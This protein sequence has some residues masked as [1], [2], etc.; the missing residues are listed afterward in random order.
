MRFA[1]IL[2]PLPR[3]QV[4]SKTVLNIRA[5]NFMNKALQSFNTW[6]TPEFTSINRLPM[7]STLYPYPDEASA[8]N[9]PPGRSRL[10]RS[11]NG[12]W[13]FKFFAKP[14]AVPGKVFH[15]SDGKDNDW[16][17]IEV[18]GNWTVQGYDRPHY[19]N[20]I[21]PFE[22]NPPF[23]PADNPTGVY[24]RIFAVPKKWLKRRTILHIGGMESCGYVYLN[25]QFIGMTKDSRLPAEFD[26]SP[27]LKEGDNL[28]SIMV[29]RWS[30]GSYVEDQDHWWMAG[31]H[32]DV[33]LYNTDSAYIEDVH[34]EPGLVDNYT[35]GELGVTVKLNFRQEPD[36]EYVVECQLFDSDHKPVF[37]TSLRKVINPS[38]RQDY[39]QASMTA[40]AGSVRP[41]SAEEPSLYTLVVS[42]SDHRGKLIEATRT[43]IGFRTV[44]IKDRQLL[45]NGAP[46][47]IKGVNRHDHD[48]DHGK[49][50]S[51]EMMLKDILLLK[52]FN[53][54]AVRTSHYPNDPMWYQLCDE[55]GIYVIDEANI[56]S[57][58]NPSMLCRDLRWQR[59]WFE[60]GSRMVIRDKNH[61]SIIGWSLGNESGYGENHDLLAHWIRDYDPSRILHYEGAVRSDWRQHVTDFGPGGERAN[62][63]VDPMYPHY[64]DVVEWAENPTDRKRPFIMCEYSH[65]MGNSNGN[66]KEYWDAVYKYHGLQGG[67]IWDWVDQGLRKKVP[68]GGRTPQS[69]PGLKPDEFWAYGGDFGDEPNDINFCC[70]GMIWPDRTPHPA[71]YEFKKLVQPIKVESWDIEKGVIEIHNTDFFINANWLEGEWRV[72]VDGRTVQRGELPLLDIGPQTK[73]EISVDYRQPDLKDGE[74]AFLTI[75]FVTGK[76][77]AWA[78]KGHL[79]AWEQFPLSSRRDSRIA[80]ARGAKGQLSLRE[81]DKQIVVADQ[82]GGFELTFDKTGGAVSGLK[83]DGAP[84]ITQ[85]P[86]FNIWR[87]PLDNDGIKGREKEWHDTLKPLGW[88]IAMGYDK[89]VRRKTEVQTVIRKNGRID[90]KVKQ[91]FSSRNGKTGFNH[92]HIYRIYPGGAIEMDNTFKL[93]KGARD[94]PRI[95]LRMAVSSE[96]EKLAWFGRGPNENYIDRK[97]GSPV[98]RFESTVTEQYM[99]Y[100]VPQENGNKEDVRWLTLSNEKSGGGV[101]IKSDETFGF[102]ALHFTPEQMTTAYHPYEMTPDKET[103]LLIDAIQR[104]VGNTDRRNALEK[105]RIQPG[106]YSLRLKIEKIKTV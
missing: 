26:L 63:F 6:E 44:E 34:A 69:V 96:F 47:L 35:R 75:E 39:Y 100:V 10:V 14:E 5:I 21:M 36:A 97:A 93:D 105:Y 95:G 103:T 68:A 19:T 82:D 102:S 72:E 61:P 101:R 54:N 71:M 94:V 25:G 58:A 22:N 37:D 17:S 27:R 80:P 81:T 49:T 43:R 89:L 73:K 76:E 84:V 86:V 90:I 66:L 85:G 55:Y 78:P 106:N 65:A 41:W 52:Q 79:V 1:S 12:N 70:N 28:L 30:D 57:H 24:R 16:D 2:L 104:G 62:D 64:D 77:L 11:L 32:R 8:L 38:Y 7:R 23:V 60:R 9:M 20:V 29:I 99:P 91:R 83:Y 67:F 48:P 3:R 42:L 4:Q 45:I 18:P 31:I 92:D 74:E 50:V 53:F 87:A 13:R 15:D 46:V 40:S 56:E 98:G 51:R 59:C 33:Y 88:W